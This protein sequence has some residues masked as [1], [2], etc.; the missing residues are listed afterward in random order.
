MDPWRTMDDSSCQLASISHCNCKYQ[1]FTHVN[2]YM[3]VNEEAAFKVRMTVNLQ[4]LQHFETQ[5]VLHIQGIRL[6]EWLNSCEGF[7][8][9]VVFNKTKPSPPFTLCPYI[10]II[11]SPELP[12]QIMMSYHILFFSYINEK[13]YLC[14]GLTILAKTIL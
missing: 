11:T 10:K 7:Y 5:I 13:N 1:N 14:M 6:F 12:N 8:C 2:K 4:H 3:N 9:Y